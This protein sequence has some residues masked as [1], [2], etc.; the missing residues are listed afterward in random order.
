M[1]NMLLSLRL[2]QFKYSRAPK[3]LAFTKF[4]FFFTHRRNSSNPTGPFVVPDHLRQ[5]VE[6][7]EALYEQHSHEYVV[8]SKKLWD[9]NPKQKCS[10]LYE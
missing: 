6:E 8:R 10:S 3:S 2:F 7:F 1:F 9:I 5:D 4:F